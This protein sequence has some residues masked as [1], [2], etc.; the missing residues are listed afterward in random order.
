M[1]RFAHI[2]F[3][4]FFGNKVESKV[5]STPSIAL[6]S[7]KKVNHYT[8]SIDSNNL[9]HLPCKSNGSTTSAVNAFFNKSPK[10]LVEPASFGDAMIQCMVDRP[11]L[12]GG[13]CA[14]GAS[15]PATGK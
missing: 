2:W 11:S 3:F 10:H 15:T 7:F 8:H 5:P 9:V 4:F 1:G 6:P 12:S 14:P 13:K